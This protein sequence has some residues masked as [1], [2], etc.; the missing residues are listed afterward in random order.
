MRVLRDGIT[1]RLAVRAAQRPRQRGAVV[2]V[3]RLPLLRRVH[4]GVASDEEAADGVAVEP[5]DLL[6]PVGFVA[7]QLSPDEVDLTALRLE[8]VGQLGLGLF[9]EVG[10][11]DL[12]GGAPQG[13][14]CTDGW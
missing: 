4:G 5:V 14:A 10:Q 9:D 11:A 13:D 12:L 6:E 1:A 3:V 8:H 7:D 2:G